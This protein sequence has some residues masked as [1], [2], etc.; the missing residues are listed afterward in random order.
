M[1][2][3]SNS[4]NKTEYSKYKIKNEKEKENKGFDHNNNGLS[5]TESALVKKRIYQKNQNNR[6][7]MTSVFPFIPQYF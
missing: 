3:A 2:K 5:R 4:M 6:V 7:T 1:R